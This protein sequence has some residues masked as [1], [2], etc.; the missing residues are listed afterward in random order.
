MR[1][2]CLNVRTD[3]GTYITRIAKSYVQLKASNLVENTVTVGFMPH[4][5]ES[6]EAWG[7]ILN[8]TGYEEPETYL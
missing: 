5:R 7:K 1:R 6:V 8:I 3:H 4:S 2:Y